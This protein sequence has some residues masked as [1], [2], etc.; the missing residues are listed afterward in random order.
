M[1]KLHLASAAASLGLVSA[2]TAQATTAAFSDTTDNPGNTFTTG[3]VQITDDDGGATAM[4]SVSDMLP[5]TTATRCINVTYS[6]SQDAGVRLYGSATGT[7]LTD[8]LDLTVERSTGAAGGVSFSCTG[9][10]D[11]NKLSVWTA[12]NGDFGTFLA[13]KTDYAT[14]AD[15]WAPLGGTPT[16]VSYRFTVT[17]QDDNNAQGKSSTVALT[18]ESQGV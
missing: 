14:G 8:Y 9:F 10:D 11:V 15:T 3:N 4:F 6:G 5:G 1:N 18:W 17:L 12:T 7:A 13:S 2:M 16:T